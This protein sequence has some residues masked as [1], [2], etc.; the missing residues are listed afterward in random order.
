MDLPSTALYSENILWEESI[1][2]VLLWCLT[3]SIVRFSS[4][5]NP[6][7]VTCKFNL[8]DVAN[9]YILTKASGYP[10]HEGDQVSG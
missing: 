9:G 10:A 2:A 3:P 7:M 8:W 1:Q 5:R 4:G 6:F